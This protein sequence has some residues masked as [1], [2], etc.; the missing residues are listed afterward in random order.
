MSKISKSGP[1][2]FYAKF[3]NSGGM[4]YDV[5]ALSFII[6]LFVHLENKL[7]QDK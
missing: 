3:K 5:Y 4:A 7:W 6:L 2:G 1:V